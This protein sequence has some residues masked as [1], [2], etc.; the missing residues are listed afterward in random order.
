MLLKRVGSLERYGKASHSPVGLVLADSTLAHVQQGCQQVG[1]VR[2]TIFIAFH[3]TPPTVELLAHGKARAG[4]KTMI[5][6][7][8]VGAR[9]PHFDPHLKRHG[10]LTAAADKPTFLV[11]VLRH[12]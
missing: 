4:V 1:L 8:A 10:V 7:M 11:L 6:R 2:F 3:G 5:R 12:L 9:P